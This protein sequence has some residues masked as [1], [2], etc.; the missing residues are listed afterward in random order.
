[1]TAGQGSVQPASG[2][3]T[4][5][6]RRRGQKRGQNGQ[7]VRRRSSDFAE[8]DLSL[9]LGASMSALGPGPFPTDG[10]LVGPHPSRKAECP[11]S[12]IVSDRPPQTRAPLR[13]A[14]QGLSATAP[15]SLELSV[16]AFGGFKKR[17]DLVCRN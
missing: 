12:S 11:P 13:Q 2:T 4:E 6:E 10:A 17:D 9:F 3:V 7:P 5:F 14:A 1:M 8:S 16:G 15:V